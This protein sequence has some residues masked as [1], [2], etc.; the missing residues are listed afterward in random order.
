MEKYHFILNKIYSRFNKDNLSNVPNL[1]IKYKT[2]ETE[3]IRSVCSK[4]SVNPLDFDIFLK[5]II[6]NFKDFLYAFYKKYNVEKLNSIDNIY[7]KYQDKKID[8]IRELVGKYNITPTSLIEIID[9]DKIIV[10]ENEFSQIG[11]G[12]EIPIND[13]KL[14]TPEVKR[15]ISKPEKEVIYSKS[16]PE[17]SKFETKFADNKKVSDS[18]HR[19]KI[20]IWFFLV[21][22][23]IIVIGIAGYLFLSNLKS[24]QN[25]I[26]Y[27]QK[28]NFS[29]HMADSI[30]NALIKQQRTADSIKNAFNSIEE[31]KSSDQ[32]I[33][34]HIKSL[35]ELYYLYSKEGNIVDLAN[36]FADQTER[37]FSLSNA[38]KNDI[39]S[40]RVQ[41]NKTFSVVR[42]VVDI[43]SLKISSNPERTFFDISFDIEN[44]IK[45]N[46]SD[47]VTIT[48]F[49]ESINMKLNDKFQIYYIN[50][51]ILSQQNLTEYAVSDQ[52]NANQVDQSTDSEENDESIT[53][54]EGE[55]YFTVEEMPQYRGG[56]AALRTYIAKSIKYPVIAQENGIQGKVYITFVI[57]KDGSVT[58]VKVA[59]GVDPSLDAEAVRVVK[60]L[61][62]WIP[63]KQKGEPVRVSYTI[64]VS[65]VL[66]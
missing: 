16:K 35:I 44:I 48:S 25:K 61:P 57:D 18:S 20:N 53:N 15:E 7:N 55:I 27:E 24:K 30:S 45:K 41:Y 54:K 36:L 23:F 46:D 66:Q 47:I 14:T 52:D 12:T 4:Y 42:N 34:A 22:L 56:E 28:R 39:I 33:I 59:D 37:Y 29:I 38:T 63:G 19:A 65:F 17:S 3:F 5:Y 50:E 49:Q 21:P 31:N 13:T 32:V 58:G 62:N 2:K 43:S 10:D 60:S 1:L 6:D 9:F 64:P 40:D 11:E 26:A 51:N 8:F